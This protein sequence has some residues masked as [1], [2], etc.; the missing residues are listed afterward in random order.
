MSS[1]TAPLPTLPLELFVLQ[2]RG[3]EVDFSWQWPNTLSHTGLDAIL[4]N[5]DDME[6]GFLQHAQLCTLQRL[7]SE[8]H[9]AWVLVNGCTDL[10][11][12]VNAHVLAA[13]S[14]VRLQH[15]D[16]IEIGLTRLLISLETARNLITFDLTALDARSD[17][18]QPRDATHQGLKRMDFADLIS[19]TTED[20]ATA[21]LAA[22]AGLGTAA[23][24]PIG[25]LGDDPLEAL[26]A[27]YLDQLRH[28][29]G[30][31]TGGLW[32]D[33]VRATPTHH[34]DPMQQWMQAAGSSPSLDDLL[35]QQRNMASVI[36]GLDALGSNDVLAPEPFDSVMHLFAPESLHAN[37]QAALQSMAQRSLPGLT[38]REHH[39]LSVDSAMPFTG[40]EEPSSPSRFNP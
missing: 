32:Q 2:H 23:P 14:E 6:P 5:V 39:S 36:Q 19:L 1:P 8:Q 35:G 30:G 28:P 16:E 20:Q 24:R 13:G 9:A 15:G 37:A 27:R 22:P 26:H 18:D 33:L 34:V 11:C 31:D 12:S 21:Q 4:A 25:G 40:G 38:Q 3:Q 7:G 10:V 17:T 29:A